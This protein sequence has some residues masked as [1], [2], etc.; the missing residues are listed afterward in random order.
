MSS[1][2]L[3]VKYHYL[4]P[5]LEDIGGPRRHT[6][7]GGGVAQRVGVEAFRKVYGNSI[8]VDRVVEILVFDPAFPRS[9]RFSIDRL[10]QALARISSARRGTRARKSALR[11]I[12]LDAA[13]RL[14]GPDHRG[15]TA[16]ISD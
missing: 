1:R 9:M 10:A 8:R 2:L 11:R 4:L 12:A 5:R 16:R 3:D 13:R 14:G 6:A 15:R 7:M